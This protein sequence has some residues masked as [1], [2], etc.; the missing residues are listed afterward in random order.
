MQTPSQAVASSP[1]PTQAPTAPISITVV[2]PDGRTQALTVPT[3]VEEVANLQA[4]RQELAGQLT[5]VSSRRSELLA[6]IQATPDPASRAGLEARL[7]ILDQRILQIES[8]LAA[9]GRQVASAPAHLVAFAAAEPP[10]SFEDGLMV[11]GFSVLFALGI[12]FL[13]A[14]SR[15]KNRHT[16]PSSHTEADSARLERLEQGMEAIAI[17]IERVTEGQRFVTRLLSESHA[18][19][20]TSHRLAHPVPVD[21]EQS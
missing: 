16:K 12:A 8:D 2:G 6:E 17:E 18:P 4:Q 11:G 1:A 15:W 21:K 14:R 10:D 9:T 3:T 5:S 19:L 7:K 20:G 13:F